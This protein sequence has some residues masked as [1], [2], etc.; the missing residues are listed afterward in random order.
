VE[1]FEILP[2]F[3]DPEECE[4]AL[5]LAAGGGWEP[6]RQGTGYAKLALDPGALPAPL[7]MLLRRTLGVLGEP[8]AGAFDLYLL[9]YEVG[10][11]IPPHVDPP[12]FD[13][14]L[15]RRV[16]AVLEQADRGGVLTLD[17][18]VVPLA[19]RDAVRFRP[20]AHR[21]AVSVLEAGRRLLWSVGC[22]L[23]A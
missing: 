15:H 13:G 7:R 16:N 11:H 5:A 14:A 3:V 17:G 22:N 19:A 4:A 6:G 20:D 10:S 18:E 23:P 8:P 1:P 12:L 9:R 2:G 21:H